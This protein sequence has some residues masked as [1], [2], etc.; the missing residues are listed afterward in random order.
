VLYCLGDI[1]ANELGHIK[2]WKIFGNVLSS[3]SHTGKLMYKGTLGL[4][5]NR[6]RKKTGKDKYEKKYEKLK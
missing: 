5:E 1:L 2:F 6:E 4:I 3:P